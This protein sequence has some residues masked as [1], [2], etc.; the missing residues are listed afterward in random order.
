MNC[1]KIIKQFIYTI[2][3]VFALHC[4][5]PFEPAFD[6]F[7]NLTESPV[8]TGFYVTTFENPDGT[9]EVIGIPSYSVKKINVFPNPFSFLTGVE[10]N[11]R[12]D[13]I[14]FSH[15]PEKVKIVIIKGRTPDEAIHSQSSFLGVPS[16]RRG[17]LK[18]RT[19]EKTGTAKFAMWDLKD[20]NGNYVR[21]GYYRAYFFG[22]GVPNNYWLDISLNLKKRE[23]IRY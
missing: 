9:G 8:I 2:P 12:Y 18:V 14:T 13:F 21:S 1:E 11:Y 15:L 7:L 23:L 17:I 19:I 3:M 5:S 4:S 6:D 22:E 10:I 16:V 20:E